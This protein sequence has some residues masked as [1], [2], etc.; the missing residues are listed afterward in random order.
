MYPWESA[1]HS[2]PSKVCVSICPWDDEPVPETSTSL[3][4]RFEISME[5]LKILNNQKLINYEIL[6]SDEAVKA[7]VP[8]SEI[9]LRT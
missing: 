9:R 6:F 1:E 3:A 5:Q 2:E 7:H 8:K 4:N